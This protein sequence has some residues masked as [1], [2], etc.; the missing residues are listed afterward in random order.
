[1][2]TWTSLLDAYE[3]SILALERAVAEREIPDLPAWHPPPRRPAVSPTQADWHRFVALQ[4]REAR[5]HAAVQDL[6]DGI[7]GELTQSRRT[8]AAAHAYTHPGGTPL[9]G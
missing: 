5:C 6:L 3:A 1:M 2:L 7:D 8:A 4:D 9:P